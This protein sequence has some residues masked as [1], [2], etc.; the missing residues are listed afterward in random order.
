MFK[1]FRIP[2]EG[3]ITIIGAD[4]ADGGS[5]SC[6]AVAKSKKRGDSFMVFKARMEASQFGYELNKMGL[7]IRSKTGKFPLIAVERNTG[8]ATIAVLRTLNYSPLYRMM[9]FDQVDKKEANRIGWVTNSQSRPKMLDDLALALRQRVTKI[10]DM[11]TIKEFMQFIR[12]PRSGRAEAA[13][14]SHDDLVVAEA[15]CWQLYQTASV[16]SP[17][18]L[19]EAAS[20]FPK[21]KLPEYAR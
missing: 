16:E 2:E 3:E 14:G 9:S 7:F 4:P 11:D 5:D 15:I 1:L 8:G 12:H 10:Y 18:A 21:D 6:A 17:Q 13:P 19:Q 20:R